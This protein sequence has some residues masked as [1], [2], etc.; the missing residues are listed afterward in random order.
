MPRKHIIVEGMDGSGKD[1]LI[2]Q[3][4]EHFPTHALHERAST[5][6]GGPVAN[7]VDWTVWDVETMA[8]QPASIYNRHP[9]VSEPIYADR[10]LGNPGLKPPWTM[11]AWLNDYRRMA[12]D[13]C[14]LVICQPPYHVVSGNLERSGPEAHLAGVYQNRLD[15]FTDY[16]LLVWPGPSIRYN[17]TTSNAQD[18]ANII[19]KAHDWAGN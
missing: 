17:Y 3:L 15:L 13:H 11:D 6:L 1:T 14:V 7:L 12:S 4:T 2:N 19:R 18:L 10:R 8:L 5:S 16:A 9:L